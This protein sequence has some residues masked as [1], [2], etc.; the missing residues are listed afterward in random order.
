[1][2]VFGLECRAAMFALSLDIVKEETCEF[3]VKKKEMHIG[4]LKRHLCDM[5]LG[6]CF[7]YLHFFLCLLLTGQN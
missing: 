2:E 4:S 3:V 1:M 7:W 6:F 5:V